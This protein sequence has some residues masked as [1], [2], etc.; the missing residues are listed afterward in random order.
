MQCDIHVGRT[1]V[2]MFQGVG[3]RTGGVLRARQTHLAQMP[4]QPQPQIAQGPADDRM[5]DSLLLASK[6]RTRECKPTCPDEIWI[7]R[8]IAT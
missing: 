8:L 5:C 3:Q 4:I 6:N 7:L 1:V 2:R